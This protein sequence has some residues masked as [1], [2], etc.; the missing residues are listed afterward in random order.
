MPRTSPEVMSSRPPEGNPASCTSW[1]IGS[2]RSSS[3]IGKPRK[4][5][6][7]SP[8]TRVCRS[9]WRGSPPGCRRRTRG[10][11]VA[12]RSFPERPSTSPSWT[13]SWTPRKPASTSAGRPSRWRSG[14][15][16]PWPGTSIRT[17][18]AALPCRSSRTLRPAKGPHAGTRSTR[19]PA[20]T[21]ARSVPTT[22]TDP[23]QTAAPHEIIRPRTRSAMLPA[24]PRSANHRAP[25]LLRR[26][27]RDRGEEPH[28][29]AEA[30]VERPPCTRVPFVRAGLDHLDVVRREQVPEE[31][32]ASV[33]RQEQVQILVGPTA[34]F[35][36]SVQ[37]REDPFVRG[38]EL[39]RIR[40]VEGGDESGDVPE[41]RYE[42][43]RAADLRL[44][45]AEVVS[46]ARLARNENP[47]CV[48]PVFLNQRP[49]VDH[50]PNRAMHRVPARIE[51]E[52]M[53]E[54][55]VERLRL[56]HEQ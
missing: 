30:C 47:D 42:L 34:R 17:G 49:G 54:H 39:A 24:P 37:L 9:P 41:L 29:V 1:G 36:E 48:G 3:F 21:V 31:L 22:P 53:D 45:D 11:P 19:I 25:N 13:S 51:A 2:S 26:E 40:L 18:S 5:R 56:P 50:V 55:A 14:F 33:R 32:P 44:V 43:R 12:R 46:R 35:D 10:S 23:N 6:A 28:E 15:A 27:R 20:P 52:A 38:L 16:R 4:R 8:R 7:S